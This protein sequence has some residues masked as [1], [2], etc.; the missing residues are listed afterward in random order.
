MKPK[1]ATHYSKKMNAYFCFDNAAFIW[2]NLK[3]EWQEFLKIGHIE[4]L[5]PL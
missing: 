4:D 1:E 3:N 5:T 2:C